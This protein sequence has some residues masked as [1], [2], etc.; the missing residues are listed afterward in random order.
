[1]DAT[2]Y[3]II[4]QARDALV[5]GL[6]LSAITRATATAEDR[7]ASLGHNLNVEQFEALARISEE[8]Y[9]L[10]M[11]DPSPPVCVQ[12]GTTLLQ[13]G[14]GR[15]R[16]FCS[17]ACKQADYRDRMGGI[18]GDADV[19]G[20][21]LAKGWVIDA[22]GAWHEPVP[23]CDAQPNEKPGPAR[24]S[25]PAHPTR[26]HQASADYIRSEGQ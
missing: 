13:T 4:K 5:D 14:I 25:S 1:M 21:Y 26:I 8:L 9:C 3:R 11:D 2:A 17:D 18:E 22:G 6:G 12:C 10:M 16:R 19:M 20:A 24:R 15:P 7:A 23:A